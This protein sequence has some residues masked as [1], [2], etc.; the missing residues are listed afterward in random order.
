MKISDN[1]KKYVAGWLFC[2]VLVFGLTISI[3][4]IAQF[5]PKLLCEDTK[6]YLQTIYLDAMILVFSLIVGFIGHHL[7]KTWVDSKVEE[8]ATARLALEPK[9]TICINM[10]AT[11]NLNYRINSLNE[12]INKL[13]EQNNKSDQETQLLDK[14]QKDLNDLQKDLPRYKSSNN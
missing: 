5:H 13:N 12:K 11:E 4:E 3:F 8:L 10:T 7:Y 2:S 1:T 14:Y 9:T 6:N